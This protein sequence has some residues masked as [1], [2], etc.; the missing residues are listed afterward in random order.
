MEITT[1]LTIVAQ[2]CDLEDVQVR[3]SDTLE[4][5]GARSLQLAVLSAQLAD[6]PGFNYV[7]FIKSISEPLDQVYSQSFPKD[8]CV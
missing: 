8:A 5:L 6:Y 3:S 1:F 7:A 2:A 4:S